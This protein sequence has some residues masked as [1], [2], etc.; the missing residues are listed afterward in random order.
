MINSKD[1]E[2]DPGQLW[3]LRIRFPD[4]N[5]APSTLF[6][7]KTVL[8][9]T[10]RLSSMHHSAFSS[11]IRANLPPPPPPPPAPHPYHHLPEIVHAIPRNN[12]SDFL[13]KI[14]HGEKLDIQVRTRLKD[15]FDFRSKLRVFPY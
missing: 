5:P 7:Y 4:P 12:I 14:A 6:N 11:E 2:P 15:A 10:S 9:L 1:S 8:D 13:T 3:T